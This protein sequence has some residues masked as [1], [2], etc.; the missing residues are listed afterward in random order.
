MKSLLGGTLAL[1]LAS[2][3]FAAPQTSA[4]DANQAAQTGTAP[5]ATATKGKGKHTKHAKEAGAN[6]ARKTKTK[7]AGK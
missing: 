3:A 6:H 5:A 2:F 4:T 7:P 1:M